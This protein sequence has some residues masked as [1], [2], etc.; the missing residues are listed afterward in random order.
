MVTEAAR[1]LLDWALPRARPAYV[2]A[3]VFAD[4]PISARVLEKLGFVLV[5]EDS[6]FSLSRQ[7]HVPTLFYCYELSH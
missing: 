4:N 2:S 1:G 3:N 7:A 6:V 5:G